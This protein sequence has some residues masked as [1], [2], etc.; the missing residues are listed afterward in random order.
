MEAE[1]IKFLEEKCREFRIDLIDL[2]YKIQTGHPGGSLS[3]VEILT[4]LYF[5]KLKVDASNPKSEDR[6]R[7]ILAKGH[8]APIYYRI[9]AEKGFFPKEEMSTLRQLNSRL[10][11]HPCAK[12]TPGV[13]LSTGPL[14]LGLSA[15]VGM[16]AAAKQDKKSIYTYVLMGDG[17]LQE[18][19]VWEAAMA[20][21]KFKLDNLIAIVD[22]NGVQLDGTVE[23]IMPMGSLKDKWCAFGWQVI[24]TDGHDILAFSEAVDKAKELK[25]K[26]I[27]I[28][29]KTV[30]G[31][32]ISFMEGKNA[33][34]GKPISS[35]E[36]IN[37]LI[38]LGA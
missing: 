12:K 29:A 25:G 3:A 36:H 18:G 11:G 27:V 21:S 37:A 26:P 33:W 32:G 14:G 2:L 15:A 5:D 30:K 7:F 35:E 4:T 9:L 34:H 38:E 1:R 8:A 28:I 24:E 19:I 16:A 20:A 17:E 10:Q 31:K 6:D 13:E 22:N 23:E